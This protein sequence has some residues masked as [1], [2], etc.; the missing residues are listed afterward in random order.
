MPQ[1]IAQGNRLLRRQRK[2]MDIISIGGYRPG[3]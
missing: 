3:F 2:T 1:K